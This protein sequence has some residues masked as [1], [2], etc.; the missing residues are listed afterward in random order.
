MSAALAFAPAAEAPKSA[1][2][3]LVL[4]K[5]TS[6]EAARAL[7]ALNQMYGYFGSDRA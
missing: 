3:S 2:P 7:A 6:P 4:V 5:N 1:A